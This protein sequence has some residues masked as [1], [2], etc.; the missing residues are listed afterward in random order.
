[1][2]KEGEGLQSF[3]TNVDPCSPHLGALKSSLSLDLGGGI[4]KSPWGDVM[5]RGR[6]T[7][8]RW[9]PLNAVK[10]ENGKIIAVKGY[11]YPKGPDSPDQVQ[12]F[13]ET[14]NLQE[15]IRSFHSPRVQRVDLQ[16][17]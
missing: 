7:G 5:E 4:W 12:S 11:I 17:I 9:R 2:G 6:A 8:E 14:Q 1:L 13:L 3:K 16:G 10:G 15:I